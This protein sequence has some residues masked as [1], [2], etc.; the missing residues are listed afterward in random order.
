MSFQYRSLRGMK[1]ELTAEAREPLPG[2]VA[3]WCGRHEKG[4]GA[5]LPYCL[6][7]FL[8]VPSGYRWDGASGPTIDTPGTMYPSL[9]HDA[10]YNLIQ[11]GLLDPR[12]RPAVDRWFR[13]LLRREGV[14][15]IRRWSWWAMLRCFGGVAAGPI[16]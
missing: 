2:P 9:I 12:A 3:R 16:R 15:I 14:G 1:Y 13:L 4:D 11:R 7:Q 6:G 5:V 8:V 10:C